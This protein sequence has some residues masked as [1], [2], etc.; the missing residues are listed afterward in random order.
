MSD[1][2]RPP[3]GTADDGESPAEEEA[4]LSDQDLAQLAAW[5][6]PLDPD[7]VP[8]TKPRAV[9]NR[10]KNIDR[11]TEAVDPEFL[12]RLESLT[13]VGDRYIRVP[14]PPTLT[15]ERPLAK[16]DLAAW[17][18]LEFDTR[19]VERPHEITDA[20]SERAPQAILRDLHRP[21]ASW[22]II[23]VPTDMGID[24]GGMDMRRQIAEAIATPYR[25]RVDDH[26]PASQLAWQ[27]EE[28]RQA[29]MAEPWEAAEVPEE[30]RRESG[31]VPTTEDIRWFGSGGYD[32][33][34]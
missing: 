23:L 14:P 24:E 17:Q 34:A 15:V 7:A 3:T 33:T 30:N 25:V 28:E 32:P 22:Q 4:A 9:Q 1:P 20:I 18:L 10:Q 16:L 5:F 31:M 6:G 26:T 8:R 2:E 12:A 27:Y 13:G 29:R 21:V 11:A 19:E